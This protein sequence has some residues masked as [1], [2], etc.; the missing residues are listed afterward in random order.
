LLEL[1]FEGSFTGADGEHGTASGVAFAPGHS[2]QGALFDDNDTL[3][4]AAYENIDV[5]QGSIEFW[6]KP[7]WNGDDG[8]S[9]VFFE[10]GDAWFNRMRIMKDGANNFRFMVWSADTEYD[11]AYNV[12]AWNANEWHHVRVT[13]KENEIALYLDGTLRDV[14]TGVASPA[15]LDSTLHLGSTSGGYT[16]AQAIVDEFMIYSQP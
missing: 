13:W 14:E 7:L 16:Q 12:S 5:E 6:L 3:G 11:V 1:H 2:G 9:Y 8:E 15:Y 4:Y 10:I